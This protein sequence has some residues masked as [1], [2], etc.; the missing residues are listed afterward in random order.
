LATGQQIYYDLAVGDAGYGNVWTHVDTSEIDSD[1][2][3][4]A[5]LQVAANIRWYIIQWQLPVG[6][7]LPAET[8]LAELYGVS[9]DTVRRAYD[10][11][12][13][14]GMLATKRGA[15]TFVR[16]RPDMQLVRVGHG[17]RITAVMRAARSPVAMEALTPSGRS[18]YS[19][20][21][22]V[23]EPGK[24]PAHYDSATTVISVADEAT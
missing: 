21:I 20:V 1:G 4:P 17:S 5:Y 18:L 14:Y 16:S 23:E 10:I 13:R 6:S 7:P 22:T 24:E 3:V 12:R 2:I 15:G 9:R 8:E 11:L 19:P